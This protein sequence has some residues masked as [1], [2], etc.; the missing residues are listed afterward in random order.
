MKNKYGFFKYVTGDSKIHKMSSKMKILL[1]LILI[2]LSLLFKDYIS[3]LLLLVFI[4]FILACTNIPAGAYIR[5]ILI[6]WPI[7]VVVYIITMILSFDLLLPLII[8]LKLILINI[9]L[10]VLTFTTSLSEI[11]WGFECLFSK[12]KKIGIP[13]SKI[14]L[15]IA[16]SLKLVATLFDQIKAVRKSMAYRG[17]PYHS[18]FIFTFKKILIPALSL[19][20]RHV[21]TVSSAMKTRFYGKTKCRTNYHEFKTTSFDKS[22]VVISLVLLYITIAFGFFYTK[23]SILK[24]IL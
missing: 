12:L 16:L 15:R 2:L 3:L 17:L 9:I 1:V 22:L 14:S 10:L 6:I 5:N 7:Y 18:G 23:F 13:V 19:S 4:L 8:V 20:L 11:A 21:K 24:V